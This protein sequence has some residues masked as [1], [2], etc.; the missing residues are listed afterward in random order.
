MAA[1][2]FATSSSRPRLV[3]GFVRVSCRS[4]AASIHDWSSGLIRPQI[5]LI[6]AAVSF[7]F[8]VGPQLNQAYLLKASIAKTDQR[9]AGKL[10]WQLRQFADSDGPTDHDKADR[11]AFLAPDPD[12]L[13]LK[14]K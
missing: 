5:D 4:R 6:G 13:H 2:W 14:H 9:Q 10:H 7:I 3:G 8:S 11:L 12:P 1:S